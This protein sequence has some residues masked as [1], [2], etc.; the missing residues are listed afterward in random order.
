MLHTVTLMDG[1]TTEVTMCNDVVV[2]GVDAAG[3]YLGLV[4]AE[5]AASVA[6]GPPPDARA[7]WQWQ[8]AWVYRTP[9]VEAC[10]DALAA[11]DAA[12][13]SARLRYITDVPG[14]SATYAEKRSQSAAY[15]A[16]PDGLVP[17]FVQAEAD[18][19]ACTPLAA[20]QYIQATAQAWEQIGPA[21][22]RERRRG[23]L[24]VA[25]AA[26][27]DECQVCLQAALAALAA[28]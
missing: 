23:K 28:V 17:P 6:D 18:A 21:V 16:A 3:G 9:L 20:A 12:A 7:A 15:I 19:M 26:T 8:G 27:A 2:H 22:E 1:S 14:Q 4:S 24:A 5:A 25:A 13:G 10:A 11:I